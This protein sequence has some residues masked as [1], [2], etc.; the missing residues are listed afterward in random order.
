MF[1][2]FTATFHKLDRL[3]CCEICKI[4][5]QT[6]AEFEEHRRLCLFEFDGHREKCVDLM[7]CSAKIRCESCPEASFRNVNGI[8]THMRRHTQERR[9]NFFFSFF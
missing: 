6:L 1:S 4:Y 3:L 8:E 5:F 2:L 7:E 9:R